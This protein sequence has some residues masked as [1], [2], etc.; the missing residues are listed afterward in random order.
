MAPAVGVTPPSSPVPLASLHADSDPSTTPMIA[1]LELPCLAFPDGSGPVPI[2]SRRTRRFVS[3]RR[4]TA[5]ERSGKHFRRASELR[6]GR[7]IFACDSVIGEDLAGPETPASAKTIAMRRRNVFV[8]GLDEVQRS[9]IER[10]SARLR[11]K[12]KVFG[13]PPPTE[14]GKLR[15][16]T[17]LAHAVECIEA[18]GVPVDAITG[19]G[20]FPVPFVVARL[21][22][23]Y[24]LPGPTPRA[25]A[26]CAHAWWSRTSR[27]RA[28]PSHVPAFA[29]F[30]PFDDGAYA[31][32]GMDFPFRIEP[33]NPFAAHLGFRVTTR[34]DLARAIERLRGQLPALKRPFDEVL[35]AVEVPS[36]VAAIGSEHCIAEQIVGGHGCT[37][38]AFAFDEEVHGYAVVD[39]V[40]QLRESTL[41]RYEYPSRLPFQI[42]D[43]LK[44]IARHVAREMGLDGVVVDVQL[45]WDPVVD[46]IWLLDVGLGPSTEYADLLEKV[47]GTSGHAVALSVALGRQPTYVHGRGPHGCAAKFFVHAVDDALVTRAPSAEELERIRR[48]FP[49][50]EVAIDVHEGERLS[51]PETCGARGHDLA[52]ITMAGPDAQRLVEDYEACR[53]MLHFEVSGPNLHRH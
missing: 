23:R 1:I 27:V 44:M 12:C 24:G 3:V 31:S 32:V 17:M 36:E 51:A 18:A 16:E 33:V 41:D 4:A 13:L 6:G 5:L 50:T 34:D 19:F 47:D 35:S 15:P 38:E 28:A 14:A 42:Q 21:C 7:S 26:Q 49:A 48:T 52:S 46:R 45:S 29:V 37:V 9:H 11:E 53:R 25:V 40:R 30:D 43:Q 39:C 22:E 8:F 2:P 10:V 20:P